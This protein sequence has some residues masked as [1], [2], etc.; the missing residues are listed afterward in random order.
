[1]FVQS[2]SI[3]ILGP[4]KLVKVDEQSKL[5]AG[6]FRYFKICAKTQ[7]FAVSIIDLYSGIGDILPVIILYLNYI[8]I[9]NSLFQNYSMNYLYFILYSIW[10]IAVRFSKSSH[11]H[12]YVQ[13]EIG[14]PYVRYS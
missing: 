8:Y 7:Y 11:Y 9:H 2:E 12:I 5:V 14:W 3:V 10:I 13:K 4:V 1:M 6:A